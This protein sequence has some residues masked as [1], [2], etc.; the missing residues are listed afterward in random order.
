ME[1]RVINNLLSE[2]LEKYQT[3]EIKL[4]NGETFRTFYEI[5]ENR[6]NT[7][8]LTHALPSEKRYFSDIVSEN[9]NDIINKINNYPIKSINIRGG[10]EIYSKLKL[11]K[12]M[13]ELKFGKKRNIKT[14]LNV[15]NK[16]IN[17]LN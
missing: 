6:N 9:K 2:E 10:P 1:S 13:K 15:L 16:D 5:G 7:W 3:L 11:H 12:R 14:R 17:F 8:T 4:E